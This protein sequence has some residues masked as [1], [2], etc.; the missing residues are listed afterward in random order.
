MARQVCFAESCGSRDSIG[1]QVAVRCM[2]DRTE[3]RNGG[4]A[5]ECEMADEMDRSDTPV[6]PSL[7]APRNHVIYDVLDTYTTAT[8]RDAANH[9]FV[10]DAQRHALGTKNV[11]SGYQVNVP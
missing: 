7:H 11:I 10:P 2:E 1:A 8:T 3:G 6:G 4:L 9:I 5:Q